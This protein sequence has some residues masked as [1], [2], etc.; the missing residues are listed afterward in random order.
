MTKEDHQMLMDA[1]RQ[2]VELMYAEKLRVLE[3]L[4]RSLPGNKSIMLPESLRSQYLN[5]DKVVS[6]T[7]Q[8]P[9]TGSLYN[10]LSDMMGRLFSNVNLPP[11]HFDFNE[12]TTTIGGSTT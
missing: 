1:T 12:V 9:A 8:R 5:P 2:Q 6:I 7:G 11:L 4:I 10:S 3:T